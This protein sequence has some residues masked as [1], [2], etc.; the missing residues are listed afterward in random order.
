MER[1]E[2]FIQ[3]IKEAIA[4]CDVLLAVIG[5]NWLVSEDSGVRWLENPND[6]VRLEIATALAHQVR[7]IPVLVQGATMPAA[8]ALPDDLKG[9]ARRQAVELRDT[10]WE[11]DVDDLI[12]A[13]DKVLG[14]GRRWRPADPSDY[15]GRKILAVSCAV[16]AV[17]GLAVWAVFGGRESGSKRQTTT[18]VEQHHERQTTIRAEQTL[19]ARTGVEAI[20]PLPGHKLAS[21]PDPL[22]GGMTVW[23]LATG[24]S[25]TILKD[26]EPEGP[27][28]I[29]A[30]PEGRLALGYAGGHVELWSPDSGI[31]IAT[32]IGTG[33]GDRTDWQVDQLKLL[34]GG[35]FSR[36]Q[37]M[38]AL[39][40]T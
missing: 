6:P 1:G 31:E 30:I 29:A 12:A 39:F 35:G 26:K 3:A 20:A 2:D 37:V 33:L 18:H 38:D 36:S 24:E 5:R 9:L 11:A 17:S 28:A 16:L 23:D 40:W 27:T 4:S 15:R 8:E 21:I 34:S 14:K 13:L 22:F 19:T 10:R 32:D 7:V 25:E